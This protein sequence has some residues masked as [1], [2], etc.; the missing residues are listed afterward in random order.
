MKTN[1][2]GTPIFALLATALIGSSFFFVAF[3]G[4]GQIFMWLVNVSS[5]AGF[6][7]WFA[8]AL[9]HY[10]FRRA[11]LKQGNSLSD[12]PFVAKFFPAAPIIAMILVSTVIVGQ[13]LSIFV[14]DD[15]GVLSMVLEFISTYVGFFSFIILY[16]AYKYVKKTKLVKLEDCDLSRSI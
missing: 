16:L 8:I 13:G 12:L 9:S 15:Q 11:Y 14:G 1:S 2:G 5:L 6:I 4:S 10:R 7:A 3:V